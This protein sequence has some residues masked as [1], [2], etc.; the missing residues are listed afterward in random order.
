MV[1]IAIALSAVAPKLRGWSRGRD[2]RDAADQFVYLTRYARSQAVSDG[3]N[4]RLTIDP[5]AG[6]YQLTKLDGVKYVQAKADFG[7]VQQIPS[8]YHIEMLPQP[9]TT[10]ISNTID[11]F[12]S[13][14]TQMAQ[15]RF[16]AAN[17]DVVKVACP[18]AAEEFAVV[19]NSQGNS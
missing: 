18:S 2:L 13:G 3:L 19:T 17:G 12:P 16:T 1:I 14:R 11:F 5:Q 7:E 4:Y 6:T 10:T 9:G 15:V 8:G